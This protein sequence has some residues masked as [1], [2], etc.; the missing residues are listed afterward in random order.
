MTDFLPDPQDQQLM[1]DS[2]KSDAHNSLTTGDI[3]GGIHGSILAGRDVKLIVQVIQQAGGT[4]PQPRN[5]PALLQALQ[6][7]QPHLTQPLEK[8]AV[9][10][11][12]AE[13]EQS[14][15]SLPEHE[16]AYLKRVCDRYAKPESVFVELEADA[17]ERGDRTAPEADELNMAGLADWLRQHQSMPELDEIQVRG[18][19]LKRVRLHSLTEG[20]ERYRCLILL[21]DP[22]S[23]KTTALNHL[24]YELA[25]QELPSAGRGRVGEGVM[26]LLLRLSEFGP[27][28]RVEDFIVTSWRGSLQSDHWAAPELA[29]NLEGYL[30]EGRLCLLLD[31][32]NEMPAKEYAHRAAAL[33]DFIDR[34]QSQGNRFVVTCRVLDYGEELHGLQRVEVQPFSDGQI[35]SLLQKVLNQHWQRMWDAL[36]AGNDAA[37]QLLKMARN[38]YVLTMMVTEFIRRQGRLSHNRAKLMDSFTQTLWRR[39]QKKCPPG[40]WLAVPIQREALAQLAFEMQ[41]RDGFGTTVE[42]EAVKAVMPSQ[43]QPDPKWP[44]RPAPADQV[45]KLAASANI[46]EM[47]VDRSTVRFYHQLLQEYFAARHM[48]KQQPS[49][50]TDLWRWPWLEREMPPVGKRGDWD[51]LPPPPPT[52]WEE[53]TILAAGLAPENDDQLVRGLIGINPVL[54]GRCLHEGPARVDG[55][56]RQKV[57]DRLLQTIAQPEVALR[58]RIAAGEVL[59]HRG[60]PRLGELVTVPAGRFV[61]GDEDVGPQHTLS[62]PEYRIGKYPLTNAEFADFIEAGGYQDRRWWTEA[63][64]REK[65]KSSLIEPATWRYSRFSRPNQPV[66]GIS[67][68]EAVAYCRWWSKEMMQTMRLPTEAE[69]EKAARGPDGRIYPWGNEFDETWINMDFG[70]QIVNATTPVGIYPS[71]ASPYGLLD[72]IGNIREWCTTNVDK[73]YPYC[74]EDEWSEKYL[75]GTDVRIM[76]GSS[77]LDS[78][79]EFITRCACRSWNHPSDRD[80]D[81]GLRIVVSLF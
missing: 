31:A 29:A 71:G 38:P 27:G 22:G 56:T 28:Q 64:W 69:W 32:L 10:A 72:C 80:S 76:R 57:I 59:G 30:T 77:W 55:A 51:P 81:W 5:Q 21:G 73:E 47:P 52:G 11:T 3:Q 65:E 74:I 37:H 13:L 61:M 1:A 63:G 79:D 49:Q 48:L 20:L 12:I 46:I 16:Q 58:V 45:L 9:A 68:Y 78:V 26:P 50:L 75:D 33:R 43:V 25:D 6:Q 54:A 2:A 35:Q 36:V 53:T 15:A 7:A 60:D 17:Y 19:E 62:L 41:Q 40:D 18:Q 34:W 70:E 4:L 24:A 8:A 44:P 23:G 42:T 67:W 14:L 39:A 66:V